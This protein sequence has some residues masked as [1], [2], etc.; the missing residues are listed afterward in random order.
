MRR[1]K[2][3]EEV[4]REINKIHNKLRILEILK[5]NSMKR[6]S[7]DAVGLRNTLQDVR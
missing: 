3:E 7:T 6:R 2:P 5:K 4:K 1:N